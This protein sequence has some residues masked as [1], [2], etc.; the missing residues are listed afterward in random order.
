MQ[1]IKR[2]HRLKI[3]PLTEEAWK[4]DIFSQQTI[5]PRHTTKCVQTPQTKAWSVQCL[6][7]VTQLMWVQQRK[8][9]FN[10]FD[11]QAFVHLLHSLLSLL[12]REEI[13]GTLGTSHCS[14][15]GTK[16][17]YIPNVLWGEPGWRYDFIEIF[18]F[19]LFWPWF[20]S[21]LDRW[22]RRM[23]REGMGLFLKA[24]KVVAGL[25]L[26]CAMCGVWLCNDFW[27][28]C[29]PLHMCPG[30][31]WDCNSNHIWIIPSRD[32][33]YL[34]TPDKC[35]TASKF[36][37]AEFLRSWR[38]HIQENQTHGRLPTHQQS[39]LAKVLESVLGEHRNIPDW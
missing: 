6:G 7:T 8:L 3:V 38:K 14:K 16:R 17:C 13:L 33:A 2:N 28:L 26:L 19:F 31:I 27:E 5:N 10:Y 37:W 39:L 36:I 1:H 30:N 4:E 12:K 18:F 20:F 9:G 32:I 11:M 24:T 35:W 23:E 21:S 29:K 15:R 25:F 22:V 34:G